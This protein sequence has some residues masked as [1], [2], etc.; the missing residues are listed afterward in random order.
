[1]LKNS[2]NGKCGLFAMKYS[3]VEMH[4]FI[5]NGDKR[6]GFTDWLYTEGLLNSGSNMKDWDVIENKELLTYGTGAVSKTDTARAKWSITGSG[7]DLYCPKLPALGKAEILVNGR[8][9]GNIDLHAVNQE[10][11]AV[12]FS[13]RSLN[14]NK[15]A[16]VIRGKNGK[17]ALDFL[18]VYE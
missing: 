3:G 10:K 11:S 5:V 1:M 2:N 16:I 12:V 14:E 15:N 4:S 17:I 8:V 6:P 9:V 13:M 7:F 18:R